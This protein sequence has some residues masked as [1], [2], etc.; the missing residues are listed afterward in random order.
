MHQQFS[1]KAK[2]GLKLF[3]QVWEPAGEVKAVIS[4]VHGSG[5]HSG[6]YKLLAQKFNE[7]GL[8][9]LAFDQRGSG[10][11]EGRRGHAPS[12]NVLLDDVEQL[13]D[14]AKKRYPGKARFIYGHS[15]GGNLAL[16][17]CL[18]RKPPLEGMIVTSPWLRLAVEPPLIKIIIGEVMD[19]IWPS[20]SQENGISAHALSHDPNIVR[21]YMEDP[22]VHN[23]ISVRLFSE[24]YRA[25]H[26]A[27]E[28][29]NELKIPLL[30]MHGTAD[31]ITS[32]EASQEF[33]EN[34]DDRCTFKLWNGQFHELHNEIIK[35][36]VS[37]FILNWLER[38][39][40]R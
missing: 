23:R 1:W 39:I 25:G 31:G 11:S 3:A 26:W 2:D 20:F 13:L 4:L 16:N 28:H 36:Q 22:L 19:K 14:E 38:Y 7:K 35:D 30:L 5:E 29:S 34:T 9:L 37:N 15:L 12:Y 32:P 27:L 10:Q 8:A 40:N 18:R 21:A 17:Y 33:F 6:R 24:C